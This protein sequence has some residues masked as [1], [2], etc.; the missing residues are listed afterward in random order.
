MKRLP[1]FALPLLALASPLSA[2]TS[3]SAPAATKAAEAPAADR[4]AAA[5]PVIDKLWPLGTYRKM[6]DQLMGP[7][8]DDAPVMARLKSSS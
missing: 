6:M 1:L 5:K 8:M 7:M 3:Q 2:Q 4:V